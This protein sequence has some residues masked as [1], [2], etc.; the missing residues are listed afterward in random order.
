MTRIVAIIGGGDWIDDASVEHLVVPDDMDLKE[1]R[2]LHY[3]WYREV[4]RLS[5]D[6]GRGKVKYMT[7]TQWLVKAGARP[8]TDKEVE[9]IDE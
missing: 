3:K 5:A 7:F 9:I 8:T 6:T 4:Y 2:L 1:Q